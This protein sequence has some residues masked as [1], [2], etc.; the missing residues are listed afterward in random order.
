MRRIVNS[1][2]ITLDGAV[3]NPHVWPS[4]GKD[5][6][7][8]SFEIQN[9]LLQA[10]D[11]VLMGRKTYEAF[12]LVWPTRSGDSYCD[13]INTIPKYVVSSTLKHASW[14]NTTVIGSNIVNEIAALKRQPGKDIVQYGL[15]PV[16]FL[17]MENGLIDEFRFW[18]HPLVLGRTGPTSPHFLNCPP[19]RFQ[20]TGSRSLPNGIAILSYA[21]STDMKT[22]A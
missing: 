7:E 3:E 14:T 20:L 19:A 13:R 6:S 8:I 11:G 4:L 2:Y 12:A 1:T 9:E 10:C 18:V 15:G 17:L 5:G 21:L 16:S 22:A